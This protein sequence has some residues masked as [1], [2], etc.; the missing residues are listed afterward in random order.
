MPKEARDVKI[1]TFANDFQAPKHASQWQSAEGVD[2]HH[3]QKIQHGMQ[4]SIL[5]MGAGS[6]HACHRQYYFS[7]N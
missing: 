6:M 2:H 7:R 3:R 5:T 4:H 1:F